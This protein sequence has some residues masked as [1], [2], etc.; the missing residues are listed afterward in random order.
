M[1]RLRKEKEPRL[2]LKQPDRSIPDP[3]S[4][5]LLAL[6]EKRGLLKTTLGGDIP[7]EEE[8]EDSDEPPAGRLADAILWT[9]SLTMLHFT[10]DVLVT[11]QYAVNLSW[12]LVSTRA[13][14]AFPRIF[15]PLCDMPSTNKRQSSCY[16]STSFT[17]TPSRPDSSPPCPR[18]PSAPCNRPSSSSAVWPPAAI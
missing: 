17:R 11:H 5:T 1:A 8:E 10:L 4:E 12:P 7:G 3:S 6:A 16:S 13:A 15:P 18:G 14:Q 9:L 2:K